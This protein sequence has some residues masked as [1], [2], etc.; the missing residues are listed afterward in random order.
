MIF[1]NETYVNKPQDCM[2][3]HKMIISKCMTLCNTWLYKL[4]INKRKVKFIE[5]NGKFGE[6][7]M[8][9]NFYF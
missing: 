2:Y 7:T 3:G 1:N 5:A 9:G 4:N 8:G 6:V